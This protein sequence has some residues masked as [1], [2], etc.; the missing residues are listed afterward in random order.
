MTLTAVERSILDEVKSKCRSPKGAYPVT[1][2]MFLALNVLVLL[3]KGWFRFED[4]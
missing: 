4:R 3:T 2:R 1:V